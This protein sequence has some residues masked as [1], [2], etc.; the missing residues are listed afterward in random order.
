MFGCATI[1][2]R[3]QIVPFEGML[4]LWET[5]DIGRKS[6]ARP[7]LARGTKPEDKKYNMTGSERFWPVITAMGLCAVTVDG[8]GL[9]FVLGRMVY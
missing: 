5:P 1:I 7:R 2:Q 9:C 6:A 3:F 4:D 8:S